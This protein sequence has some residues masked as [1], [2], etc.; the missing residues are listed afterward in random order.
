[1]NQKLQLVNII[2][3]YSLKTNKESKALI[4]PVVINKINLIQTTNTSYSSNQIFLKIPKK[5]EIKTYQGFREGVTFT[6]IYLQNE[7][8]KFSYDYA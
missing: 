6:L 5:T 1:M 4:F 3:L 7:T 8:V 2:E